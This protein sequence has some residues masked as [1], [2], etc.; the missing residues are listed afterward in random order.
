M[1]DKYIRNNRSSRAEIIEKLIELRG[2]IC[3]ICGSVMDP[4]F[5]TIDHILPV[6]SGGS[7]E[8]ENLQ[9]LCGKCNAFKANK[10]FLGYQFE[11]YMRQLIELNP[12]YKFVDK[13]PK[14]DTSKK[15]P[16]LVFCRHVEHGDII[17]VAEVAV[18]HSFTESSVRQRIQR[19]ISYRTQI[20]KVNLAFITPGELPQKYTELIKNSDIELWDKTFIGYEFS[21]ELSAAQPSSF[22]TYF[23]PTKKLDVVEKLIAELR[24]CPTGTKAW[25]RYQKLVEQILETVFCP[26]LDSPICQ[27]NDGTKKNRRDFIMPNYT[28]ESNSWKFLREAYCA[29]FVVVDSKNSGKFITKQ[30]V[31][32]IA[33]YLKKDGTGLFGIIIARKGAN[34][35]S[36]YAMREKWLYEHK[37]IVVLNDFDVE[38]MLLAKKNNSD[39]AKL[40]LQKIQEFRLSV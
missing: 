20:P 9:L 2:N 37:M 24:A 34:S 23:Q 17:I 18:A 38:Q 21:E 25:G 19:L 10:P 13:Q 1:P 11:S 27:S 35:A 8:I 16:D 15:A 30:D 7:D 29:E 39:P 33:N 40:I 4:R 14:L 31:F 32:Q 36:E 3:P 6:S 28:M 22:K 26:P 5:C 12:R